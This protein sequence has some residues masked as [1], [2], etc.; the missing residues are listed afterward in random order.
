MAW[1]GSQKDKYEARL[2]LF[3][4]SR[5]FPIKRENLSSDIASVLFETPGAPYGEDQTVKTH[6]SLGSNQKVREQ[7]Q[8]SHRPV[9]R[10]PEVGGWG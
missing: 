8:E 3:L 7:G 2:Y 6:Q 9:V 1:C 4:G 5:G 10:Q